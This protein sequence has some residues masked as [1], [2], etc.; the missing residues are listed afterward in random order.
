MFDF[1]KGGK[2]YVRLEL[3]RP[4]NGYLPGETV[5]AKVTVEGEKDIKIQQGRITFLYCEEYEYR[6]EEW[7]RD[8]KGH[9]R[10]VQRTSRTT[11]EREVSKQ[12]FL[13]ESTIA[14]GSKQDYEFN[15][16]I[17]PDAP[18]FA[19]GGIIKSQW[20]VKATL[21]RKMAGDV[22]EKTDVY[23]LTTV[24]AS[25]PG[26]YGE[27]NE[28]GEAEMALSLPATTFALGETIEGKLI[29]R[30]R[31]AFDA[32]EVR[33]ELEQNERVPRDLGH[34]QKQ[35]QTVKLATGTKLAPGNDLVLPFTIAVPTGS[36][37][38][39]RTPNGSIAWK[40]KGV[41]ARRLRSDTSVE[42]EII[43]ASVRPQ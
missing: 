22:E 32:N 15:F 21:D 23:V 17:P 33:I 43:V 6:H 27:C 9:S 4:N 14:A 3:D 31:K 25:Q 2:A 20:L 18:P 5:Q 11:D 28:P 16:A 36:A 34:E 1:L 38:T 37:V 26:D 42:Q 24:P 12:V 10:R 40:L 19:K 30:P 35:T 7:V 41:L 39:C 13:G 8:S 29:I